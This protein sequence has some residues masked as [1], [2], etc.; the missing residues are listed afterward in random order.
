M[1]LQCT[2]QGSPTVILTSGGG[3][4]ADAWDSPLGE[5]P[6]V[7]PTIAEETRV[8]AYDRPGTTRAREEGGADGVPFVFDRFRLDGTVLSLD[9]LIDADAS[10]SPMPIDT[11]D[12]GDR[13]RQGL[14]R[15]CTS[16][17]PASAPN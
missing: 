10:G 16:S 5:G 9:E 17:P 14:R 15:W 2:G 8:C 6:N 7:Y 11:A 13:T 4:A 1:Y 12:A 3:I